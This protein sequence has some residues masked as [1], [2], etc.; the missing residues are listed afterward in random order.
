MQQQ[1]LQIKAAE[2]QR[3]A[4]KDQVDAQMRMAATLKIR[5]GRGLRRKLKLKEPNLVLR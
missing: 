4:Q 5:A 1:E 3:K 2:V